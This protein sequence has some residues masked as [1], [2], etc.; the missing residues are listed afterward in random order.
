MRALVWTPW[1]GADLML[2]VFFSMKSI[3]ALLGSLFGPLVKTRS[4]GQAGAM[5]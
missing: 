3:A 1:Y 4:G 5:Y 2:V